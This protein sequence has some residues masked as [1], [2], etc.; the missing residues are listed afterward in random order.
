[1]SDEIK[2]Y[3]CALYKDKT[4]SEINKRF[5]YQRYWGILKCF[6]LFKKGIDFNVVFEGAEDIDVILDEGIHY[7][8]IKTNSTKTKYTLT[9]L[10][11]HSGTERLSILSKL[12]GKEKNQHTLS[13][14]I[15]SNLPFEAKYNEPLIDYNRTSICFNEF[16]NSFQAIVKNHIFS[17]LSFAPNLDKY[18]YNMS[19]LPLNTL[20]QTMLGYTYDFVDNKKTTA[21]RLELFFD[22]IDKEA[23][24]K[25]RKTVYRDIICDKSFSRQ[26]LLDLKEKYFNSK[27]DLAYE[28][29]QIISLYT[30]VIQRKLNSRLFKFID[31]SF[32]TVLIQKNKRI[33]KNYILLNEI[34]LKDFST[35]DLCDYI[36]KTNI[37]LEG[38]LDEYDKLC[39]VIVSVVEYE[40]EGRE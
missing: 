23:E 35:K 7:Y 28:C 29:K 2:K 3:Y 32:D 19:E 6:E 12:A 39:Y 21:E 18:F 14:N 24:E 34:K 26:D 4:G 17:Q 30:P 40:M 20:K 13:L 15:V 33:V 9:T 8:Q 27:N 25:T 5:D 36:T 31:E 16:N 38:T 11:G 10:L 1:M 22:E 37:C